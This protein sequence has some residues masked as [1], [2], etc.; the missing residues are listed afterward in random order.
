MT[1]QAY[2][3]FL[4]LTSKDLPQELLQDI[5]EVKRNTF[6]DPNKNALWAQEKNIDFVFTGRFLGEKKKDFI[7]SPYGVE[8]ASAAAQHNQK[9]VLNEK[10]AWLF[11]CGRDAFGQAILKGK[12]KKN[13]I[14]YLYDVH[15]NLL[16]MGHWLVN[17]LTIKQS[18]QAVIKNLYDKGRYIRQE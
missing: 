18:E 13:R 4:E 15:D 2:K 10:G 17:D 14:V 5:I 11:I 6:Y 12:P 3:K 16:G 7:P 8:H 9:I 1:M